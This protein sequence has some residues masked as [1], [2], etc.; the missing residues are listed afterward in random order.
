MFLYP[1]SLAWFRVLLAL[2]RRAVRLV[3]QPVNYKF[4][5]VLKTAGAPYPHSTSSSVSITIISNNDGIS[6]ESV[7]HSMSHDILL[8][9]SS[10]TQLLPLHL[11][12]IPSRSARYQNFLTINFLLINFPYRRSRLYVSSLAQLS[13]IHQVLVLSRPPS[14]PKSFPFLLTSHGSHIYVSSATQL[15]TIRLAPIPSIFWT[16][17]TTTTPL[18]TCPFFM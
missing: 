5:N 8:K 1:Q 11:S 18:L 2:F 4:P 10:P 17:V 6:H 12:P 16:I 9:V 7:S 14:L 3:S 15:S 13:P